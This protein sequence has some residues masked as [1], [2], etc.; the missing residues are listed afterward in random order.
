M[1][2]IRTDL[3]VIG[4]G[5]GGL[6]VAAGAIQMGASVVLI[7]KGKMGGDCLNYGCVPSKAT[8]AVA[9]V[10]NAVNHSGQ[11][12][13]HNEKAK[14]DYAQLAHYVSE[15]INKIAPN[16]S[17]KR[18]TG[19]G[20]NVLQGTGKFIDKRTV[21]VN[22]TLVRARRFIIA[23]GSSAA[24]PVIPGLHECPF[25]TNE[26]IF[27]LQQRPAHLLVIGGG[28]IGCELAQAH[29]MMGTKVTLLEATHILPKDDLDAATVVRKQLLQQGLTLL[30]GI[31]VEKVATLNQQIQITIKE[32]GQLKTISGS[33]LLVAAGRMPNINGLALENAAINYSPRA[34]EVDARLRTSNKKVFAIGD[35]IGGFQFTHAAAYHAGIVIRNALFHLPAKVNYRAMPWVTYTTPELAQV[36]LN[37]AM[38]KQENVAYEVVSW[39]FT[40]NDRAITENNTDGFIKVL[41]G[42]KGVI[43]GATLVGEHAGELIAIWIMAIHKKMKMKDVAELIIPYPTFSEASKRVAGKYFM[44]MITSKKMRNIVK[45]LRKF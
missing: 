44:P 35:V 18:F 15:V 42:K 37:E 7:E 28:P 27:S 26:T 30:E 24:I 10:A 12:S 14:V 13:V 6:S 31:S 36:G 25:Y 16:D 23:T 29:V 22:D 45:F 32:A 43:L 8:I 21:Q 41:V 40:E 20:V 1:Q 11:Y 3:C 33:H 17:I 9:R 4:A 19:L 39:P 34:I 2:N 38:A 5:S